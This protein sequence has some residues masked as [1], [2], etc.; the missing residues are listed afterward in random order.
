MVGNADTSWRKIIDD[1]DEGARMLVH[2]HGARLYATAYRLCG[3]EADAED[4]A[5]RTMERAIERI[6]SFDGRSM[7]FTWLCSIMANFFR[8]DMR[9]KGANALVFGEEL[10][11]ESADYST[12]NAVE[13]SDEAQTVREAVARL[14]PNFRATVTLVYFDG[15]SVVE[16]AKA[17]STPEGTVHYWLHEAKKRIKTALSGYV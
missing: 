14:P 5:F 11:D 17:L 4:L 7:F 2:E 1:P 15:M 3:N 9:R 13:S 6:R 16:A 8:M 10:P 12:S